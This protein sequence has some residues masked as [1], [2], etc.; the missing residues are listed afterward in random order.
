[1]TSFLLDRIQVGVNN[2]MDWNSEHSRLT[3]LQS[4]N[5]LNIVPAL[6][7]NTISFMG[8]NKR[9]SYIATKKINEKFLALDD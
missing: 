7:R 2:Y 6:H 8:M 1:M 3:F 5:A 4:F 9:D